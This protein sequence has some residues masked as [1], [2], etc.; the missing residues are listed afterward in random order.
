MRKINCCMQNILINGNICA[1]WQSWKNNLLSLFIVLLLLMSI[2]SCALHYSL[3]F[4][5]FLS[6]VQSQQ[7]MRIFT[8]VMVEAPKYVKISFQPRCCNSHNAQMDTVYQFSRKQYISCQALYFV[9]QNV[10]LQ[11]EMV[12]YNLASVCCSGDFFPLQDHN[13]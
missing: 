10:S 5:A 13:I 7:F 4:S 2:F 3:I 9:P 1:F 11:V 8:D 12:A 6:V